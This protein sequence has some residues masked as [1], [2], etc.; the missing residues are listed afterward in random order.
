MCKR[1]CTLPD[2]GHLTHQLLVAHRLLLQCMKKPSVLKV[3][4]IPDVIL[5]ALCATDHN[6]LLEALVWMNQ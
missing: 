6:A 3:R 5:G 2:L 4:R 1:I